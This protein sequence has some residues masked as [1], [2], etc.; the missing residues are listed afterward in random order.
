MCNFR[1]GWLQHLSADVYDRL[2]SCQTIRA[3]LQVL[4]NA[5]W[6][7][8]QEAG[9]ADQGFTKEDALVAVLEHLDCNSQYF[10]LT[11]DEYDDLCR[12]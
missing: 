1:K 11:L 8:Y 6:L 4:V 5:K 7:E 10:D 2:C 9:K 12:V 3:D